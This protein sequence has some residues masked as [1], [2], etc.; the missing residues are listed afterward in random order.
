MSKTIKQTDFTPPQ[1]AKMWGAT[2]ET[3]MAHVRSG[4]LQAFNAGTAKRP[5]WRISIGAIED[6][7]RRRSHSAVK[8]NKTVVVR[9]LV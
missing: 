9:K 1:V 2:S 6:F 4:E 7:R 3:V 5:R 8:P